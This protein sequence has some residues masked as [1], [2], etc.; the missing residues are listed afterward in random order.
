ME[1]PDIELQKLEIEKIKVSIERGKIIEGQIRTLVIVLIAVVGGVSGMV[2]NIDKYSSKEFV[3]AISVLGL[4]FTGLITYIT[5]DLWFE[6]E[7][8]KKKWKDSRL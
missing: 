5:L 4:F 1:K 6:L 7:D 2:L 8:L 3:I